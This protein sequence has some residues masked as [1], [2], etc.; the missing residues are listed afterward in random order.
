M[1]GVVDRRRS[2]WPPPLGPRDPIGH[3]TTHTHRLPKV[4]RLMVAGLVVMVV[5]LAVAVGVLTG[6]VLTLRDQRVH[7]QA[8]QQ[9]LIDSTFC[10][11]LAELPADAPPL[12][13]IRREL[14]CD[15]AQ[16]GAPAGGLNP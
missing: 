8:Q 11:V 9:A 1:A 2:P 13:R 14:H 6:W 3:P 4:V 15:I 12:Q 16:P 10:S 7:Q 5:A